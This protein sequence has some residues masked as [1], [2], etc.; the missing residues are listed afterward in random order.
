MKEKTDIKSLLSTL[1][2]LLK[3]RYSEDDII[4]HFHATKKLIHGNNI[5]DFESIK[6]GLEISIISVSEIN[7]DIDSI[8]AMLLDKILIIPNEQYIEKMPYISEDIK[9]LLLKIRKTTELYNKTQTFD[10]ENFQNLLLSIADDI[11]VILL[12]ISEKLYMLRNAKYLQDEEERQAL[13]LEVSH[14]YAPISHRLGLYQIKG[15]MEDLCLKYRESKTF[16]YIKKKLGETKDEREAYIKK[17]ITPLKELLDKSINVN[18]TIKSRT[19]S[20]SSISNKLKKVKS[21]SEIYDLFAIRIILD[22]PIE[23]ERHYC[24]QVYSIVTDLYRPNPERMKDWISIPKNNGYE[25]LHTTVIGPENRWVEVQIRTTRMDEIA[26]RGIAAHWRY[27]GIK[28]ERRLDDFM[29]SV[30]EVLDLIRNDNNS[31]NIKTLLSSSMISLQNE[32]IYVF[33]P[34]GEVVKLPMGATVLDFAFSIH[35]KIGAK[36]VSAKVND[37]NVSIKCKLKNGD[38]VH[39]FTSATQMPK[40]DWLNIVVSAKAKNRIR[41]ILREEEQ[42]GISIAKEMM[43]RRLKNRKITLND[44]LFI[45]LI[46]SKGYKTITDFYISLLNEKTDLNS[47]LDLYE[48]MY[49]KEFVSG[50]NVRNEVLRS[51][52]KFEDLTIDTD[53]TINGEIVFRDKGMDN[54]EYS[55]AKCCNPVFGDK[56]FAFI[57]SSGIKVHRVDCPNAKSLFEKKGH[58]V[59]ICNWNGHTNSKQLKTMEIIGQDDMSIITYVTSV[60]KKYDSVKIRSYSI[61]SADGLFK[62][63]FILFVEHKTQINSMVKKISDISGI[64]SVAIV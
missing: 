4:K 49:Q 24:W 30:R 7:I 58:R 21:F 13:A 55:F 22:V 56:I 17:F 27:K 51:A 3:N 36:A 19:K 54:V 37:K 52:D 57:S 45:K 59:L 48:T 53:E 43:Q 16:D 33:T 2:Q 12:L 63:T 64:K 10:S 46:K 14:L 47:F 25:S 26:E 6:K 40:S 50:H 61:D 9:S 31:N 44:S 42:K 15:E 35:S 41:Q 1:H 11:R 38:V 23:K 34:K 29:T 62:G 60:I 20:I 32:E 28:S 5:K 39:V 18:Y 8:I